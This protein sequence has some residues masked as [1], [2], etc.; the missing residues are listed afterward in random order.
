M[1]IVALVFI[2]VA[3]CSHGSKK[4]PP[5]EPAPRPEARAAQ[6]K[7]S[8]DLPKTPEGRPELAPSAQGLLKPSAA[9]QIQDALIQRGYMTAPAS[10]KLDE[11]TAEAL[12]RLQHDEELAETGAPDQET[13]RRLGL[14]PDDLY[15]TTKEP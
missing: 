1:R 12:K 2:T 7:P 9:R 11:L 4:E 15:S 5:S 10:G 14:Q 13:L 8:K 3:A 6:P